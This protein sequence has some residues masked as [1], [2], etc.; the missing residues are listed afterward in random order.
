MIHLSIAKELE[1][2]TVSSPTLQL[3]TPAPAPVKRSTPKKAGIKSPKAKAARIFKTRIPKVAGS[4]PPYGDMVSKAIKE[5]KERKGSSRAAV[6]KYIC[7]HYKVGD[8]PKKIN[9]NIKSALK[10]LV[11]SGG[12]KQVKGHGAS[13]SFRI[14]EKAAVAK[15]KKIVMKS[16]VAGQSKAPK[17]KKAK[18]TIKKAVSPKKVK[19][20][21]KPPTATPAIVSGVTTPAPAPVKKTLK[22]IKTKASPKKVGGG[23]ITKKP[24]SPGTKKTVVKKSSPSKPKSVKPKPPAAKKP[25]PPTATKPKPPTAT[26]P[27]PPTGSN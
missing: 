26:K 15:P 5:L 25:K 21:P 14:G 27:K 23:K 16:T 8:E 9:A 17:A 11:I 24:K 2:A 4:H 1:M 6:L 3:A 22:P 18:V 13:G 12:L 7:S 10:R 20:V 19:F